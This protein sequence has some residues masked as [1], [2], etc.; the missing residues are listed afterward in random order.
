MRVQT[1]ACAR[2]ALRA[3]TRLRAASL[4][5]AVGLPMGAVVR[6]F[7]QLPIADAGL[8]DAAELPRC[9]DCA[10]YL[11]GYCQMERDG[12]ICALCG[13]A[14]AVAQAALQLLVCN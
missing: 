3:D 14:P 5:D 10:A 9:A 4:R 6:P 11:C 2:G 12:W 1:A 8:P 13:T 7:A